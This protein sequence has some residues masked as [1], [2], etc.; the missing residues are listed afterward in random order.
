LPL[1]SYL[2]PVIIDISIKNNRR[3]WGVDNL[4]NEKGPANNC[5]PFV[6]ILVIPTGF[7]PVLP[8]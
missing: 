1:S 5:Q 2:E 7:E 4:P 6:F 3:P 8:A